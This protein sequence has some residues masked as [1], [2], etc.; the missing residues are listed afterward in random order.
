VREGISLNNKVGTLPGKGTK[1]GYCPNY[2]G[3]SI[4]PDPCAFERKGQNQ[5][6]EKFVL[7]DY[8]SFCRLVTK[9]ND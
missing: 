5:V 1:N 3:I 9:I 4:C 6:S 8:M 7:P 2:I